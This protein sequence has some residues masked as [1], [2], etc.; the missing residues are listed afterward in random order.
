VYVKGAKAV[1]AISFSLSLFS[2]LPSLT[3]THTSP[4]GGTEP[5]FPNYSKNVAFERGNKNAAMKI[6]H[7]RIIRIRKAKSFRFLSLK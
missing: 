1:E 5:D 3:Q 7:R 4:N 2:R 6:P